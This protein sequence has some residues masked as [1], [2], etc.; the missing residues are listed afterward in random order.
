MTNNG[1]VTMRP[2][3]SDLLRS[4]PSALIWWCLPI[5]LAL[6][7]Q[8]LGLPYHTAAAVWSLSFAWMAV[9]CLLNA[10]R[11]HRVHCFISGPVFFAGAIAAGLLAGGAFASNRQVLNDI[12]AATTV[13][14][15]SSFL[16]EIFWRKYL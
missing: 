9:G 3:R 1:D 8:P 13:L 10:R 5:A 16:P 12:I 14:V 6:A 4:P 2:D 11:C 7:A 15:A